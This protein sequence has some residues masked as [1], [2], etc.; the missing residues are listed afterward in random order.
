MPRAGRAMN[1]SGAS[2][3]PRCGADAAVFN[4]TRARWECQACSWTDRPGRVEVARL[5]AITVLVTLANLGAL[6][7]TA[8]RVRELVER[9]G[10]PR[11]SVRV[12]I[13]W[14]GGDREARIEGWCSEPTDKEE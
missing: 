12:S 11:E 4:P 9:A 7:D 2:R 13:V 10:C 6:E 14:A 8:A 5:L 1:E 3:C